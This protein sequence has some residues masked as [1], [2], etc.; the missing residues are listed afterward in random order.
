MCQL[1]TTNFRNIG[2]S[3]SSYFIEKGRNGPERKVGLEVQATSFR[4]LILQDQTDAQPSISIHRAKYWQSWTDDWRSH[5]ESP[6]R[7][8]LRINIYFI[9]PY[10]GA[11][12]VLLPIRI[13]EPS[14]Y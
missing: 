4:I 11:L 5:V 12:A 3:R 1:F 7:A 14:I 2:Q 10:D 6:P 9:M 8:P 13:K